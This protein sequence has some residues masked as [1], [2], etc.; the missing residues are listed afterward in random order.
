MTLA[1]ELELKTSCEVAKPR[2]DLYDRLERVRVSAEKIWEVQRL[3]WFTDHRAATH[4]RK[5]IGHLGNVLIHLQ[6]SP[7]KLT[8]H[9]LY[10]LLAA[11]YLHD[12]G[13]QDFKTEDGRGVDQLTPKDY[14]QIRKAHPRRA[15]ELIIDRTLWRGDRD[16]FRID[17]DD[18]A[19]Y[20]VPIALV[21][22][23]HGSNFFAETVQELRRLPHRPGNLPFRGDLLTALLLMGDELELHESRANFPKEYTLSPLALLHNHIHHYVTGVELVD[24]RTP[25]HRHIRLITEFPEDSD[26]YRAEVS[27]WL[28][29]KLSKQCE[30][31]KPIFEMTTQGELSWDSV[32]EI[33]PE[34]DRYKTRR[35][36]PPSAQ[37]ELRRDTIE[38]QSVD[39][40]EL[41]KALRAGIVQSTNQ[42]QIIRIIDQEGSDW[43]YLMKWLRAIC[44]CDQAVSIHIAFQQSAGHGPFDILTRLADKLQAEGYIC[45]IYSELKASTSENQSQALTQL[46]RAL[47]ADFQARN[48]PTP[49]VLVLEG[50]DMAESDTVSWLETTLLPEIA[51]QNIKLLVILTQFSEESIKDLSSQ[52]QTFRL[53]PFTKEQIA[54]HLHQGFGFSLENAET[55]ADYIHALSAGRPL[56]IYTA[57]ERKQR[58]NL[59]INQRKE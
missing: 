33:R 40:K 5:I 30:L 42:F 15:R 29:T 3:S 47:L 17:L 9:E 21:S 57:L 16:S 25:K 6:T 38:E 53:T 58:Q 54:A 22:Q 36:L 31:T 2:L 1:L 49:L 4:S 19:Q 59:W 12:I 24:G 55:E 51:R 45:S 52:W 10:V 26:N 8:P 20:L 43:G 32:V 34:I 18:D 46:S 11:C 27:R 41:L 7:Q 39:R 37:D 28:T 23:G 50:A 35:S 13:M 14:N 44:T 56:S 48:T